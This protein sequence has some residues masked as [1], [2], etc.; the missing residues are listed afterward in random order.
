MNM[1]QPEVRDLL[2]TRELGGKGLFFVA[3]EIHIK[4][5]APGLVPASITQYAV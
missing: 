2:P 1:W 5:T 3:Y 4:N